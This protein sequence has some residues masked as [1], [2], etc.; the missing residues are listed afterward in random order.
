MGGRGGEVGR[1][2]LGVLH[3]SQNHQVQLSGV[4]VRLTV[5]KERDLEVDRGG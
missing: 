2:L 1:R 3:D 5:R 4:G